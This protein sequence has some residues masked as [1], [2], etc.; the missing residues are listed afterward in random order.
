[1]KT[2]SGAYP[3]EYKRNFNNRSTINGIISVYIPKK[4]TNQVENVLLFEVG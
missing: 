4:I 2:T 3:F 1:M